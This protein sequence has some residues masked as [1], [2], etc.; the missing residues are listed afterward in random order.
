MMDLLNK[1]NPIMEAASKSL[2]Q[3]D[4]LA[5]EDGCLRALLFAREQRD[6]PYY[7]RILLPLQEARRRE[8]LRGDH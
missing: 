4:Y 2:A 8:T 3:M 6:W 5:C 1:L 7:A